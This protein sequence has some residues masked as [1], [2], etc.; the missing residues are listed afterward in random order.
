MRNQNSKG[1]ALT[2]NV[3]FNLSGQVLP[4]GIGVLAIP[5]VVDGLGQERFGL[6]CLVWA[7]LGYFGIFNFGLGRA[8]TNFMAKYLAQGRFQELSQ[9]IWT[10]VLLQVVLGLVGGGFFLL[11][12][13]PI[14]TKMLIISTPLVAEAQ[15]ALTYLAVGIPIFMFS[16]AFR[17]VLEGGQRFDILNIVRIPTNSLVFLAPVFS[18]MWGFGLPMVVSIL[19]ISRL[20]AAFIYLGFCLRLF[21]FLRN[22]FSF[23]F[24]WVLP[25]MRYGG[26]VSVSTVISPLLVNMDRFLIGSLNS[27]SAVAYYAAPFEM[28]TR[29]LIFPG[30]LVA[31]L[32]P[33]FSTAKA[34]GLSRHFKKYYMSSVKVIFLF[35]GV[36]SLILFCMADELLRLWLGI[37]FAHQSARTVQILALGLFLNSLAFV[38]FTFLQ[39]VGRP[40]L[41]AKFHL[42]EFPIHI[43]LMWILIEVMGIYDASKNW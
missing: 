28:L 27:V 8:T 12:I 38:P 41:T 24:Q 22:S 37:D 17:G 26:W 1:G 23:R 21:P 40:D 34:S 5:Y 2:R 14:V 19:V 39:G 33:A 3:F 13:P 7:I 29:L 10:A 32:F 15:T 9:S 16:A 43:F 31:V 4:L 25:L 30:S 42:L 36:V 6:L 20:L 11:A 18:V 35:M